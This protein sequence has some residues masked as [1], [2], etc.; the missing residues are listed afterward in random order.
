MKKLLFM[1]ILIFSLAAC[2]D[3][4]RTVF[5]AEGDFEGGSTPASSVTPPSSSAEK[6]VEFHSVSESPSDELSEWGTGHYK[7]GVDIPAGIYYAV[8]TGDSSYLGVSSDA[9]GK[10]I[11]FSRIFK[12]H[13]FFELI[14]GDFLNLSRATAIPYDDA[15]KTFDL[16][17]TIKDGM[18]IVGTHVAPGE[19]K[20]NS[21]DGKGFYAVYADARFSDTLSSKNFDGSRYVELEAGQY[22]WLNRSELL[23]K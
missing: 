18:Y 5:D 9:N 3:N 19:Y 16:D 7:V 20:L 22:L 17:G 11:L 4:D 13:I 12:T 2:S 15:P 14:D 10:D 21:T 1:F 23:L 8:S 6:T